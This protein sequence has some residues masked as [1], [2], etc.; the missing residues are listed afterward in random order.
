MLT[1]LLIVSAL[2]IV[3]IQGQSITSFETGTGFS[4][5]VGYCYKSV[6]INASMV[7]TGKSS[8]TN[9]TDYPEIHE[10]Y[11]F[12][13]SQFNHLVELVGSIEKWKTVNTPIGCPDCYNQ[14]AEWIYIDTDG[15]P[16]H[17]VQFEANS[18]IVGYETLVENLRALRHTFIH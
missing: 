8:K 16:I 10:A 17:G 12:E 6:H 2:T 15:Q 1:L 5:C 7:I 4:S 18:T 9:H 3:T 11:P 13:S 14:G